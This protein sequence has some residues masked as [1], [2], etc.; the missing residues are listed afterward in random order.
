M[1]D[2]INH[3]PTSNQFVETA[4][5]CGI[6]VMV[7]FIFMG[8]IIYQVMKNKETAINDIRDSQRFILSQLY[9]KTDIFPERRRRD[10]PTEFHRR[11]DDT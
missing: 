7:L 3:L 11:A 9:M 10:K 1:N 6:V 5:F 2:V 8:V 4:G